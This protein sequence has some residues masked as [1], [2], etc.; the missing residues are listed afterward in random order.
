MMDKNEHTYLR[1]DQSECTSYDEDDDTYTP[2]NIV[3]TVASRPI[4]KNKKVCYFHGQIVSLTA[5]EERKMTT[6]KV[7]H[8]SMRVVFI[9]ADT[10]L[11]VD[12]ECAAGYVNSS[13]TTQFPHTRY[14][15]QKLRS[16]VKLVQAQWQGLYYYETI[17]NIKAGE[18]LFGLYAGTHVDSTL[19]DHEE[20]MNEETVSD[21]ED[22]VDDDEIIS[23]QNV[24]RF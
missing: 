19:D 22:D 21:D 1:I 24:H 14:K 18:E 20:A 13:S 2:L 3:G 7:Y 8:D 9:D 5:Y 12:F 16:N 17:H 23:T 11:L 15:G 10:V 6:Y 4:P